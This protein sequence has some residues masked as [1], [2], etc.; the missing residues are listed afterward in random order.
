LVLLRFDKGTIVV[1]GDVRVPN[2]SWDPRIEAFRA[3]G[4]YYPEVLEF[5]RLSE[6]EFKDNVLDLLPCPELISK[7]KLRDYQEEALR[8][9]L[10][11]GK[12]GVIV[13][14]TGAGKTVIAIAAISYVN[15]PAIIVVPT[16]DLI[17]QWRT[18]LTKEFGVA[19]GAYGGGENTLEAIT[20]TTYD[21]AFLRAEELGNRFKLAIFDEVHHLPAPS[22]RQI[23]ELFA[24][25]FRMGLT[26]TY[27]R[28]DEGH[29]ILPKLVGN[30]VYELETDDLAGTHLSDYTLEKIFVSLTPEEQTVYKKNYEVFRNYLKKK[31]IKLRNSRDFQRFI[32]RTGTDPNAREALLARNRALDTALNASSKIE[33]LRTLLTENVDKKVL[34]FTQHNKLVYRISREFLMPAITYQT[35]KEERHDIMRKFKATNYKGIVTSKVLDEG[36]DVPDATVGVILS[37]TG[38]SR[39]FIQ[40]LGRLLRK[41][42]GKKAKLVEIVTRETR[43]TGI[44]KRRRR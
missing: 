33:A 15:A 31:R 8:A 7:T 24:T 3:M 12:R 2:S 28:E 6:V 11:A 39:E 37:G 42:E 27:I 5:L 44:S 4:I 32:M 9:W 10:E 34:I 26:A 35:S 38:S 41:K 22:Y 14:P 21:S 13:L 23:A 36:I 18:N 17:E 40:R 43:E 1:S 25:P 30:V 20:V 29:R 19:V 16:I